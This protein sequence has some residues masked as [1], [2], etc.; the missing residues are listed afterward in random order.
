MTEDVTPVPAVEVAAAEQSSEDLF[1]LKV[2]ELKAMLRV[3]VVSD[4][5]V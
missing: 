3:N 2:P 1:K 4:S 5:D